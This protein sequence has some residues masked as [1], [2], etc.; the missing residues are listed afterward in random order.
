MTRLELDPAELTRLNRLLLEEAF[1]DHIR[2]IS[3]IH[4]ERIYRQIHAGAGSAALCFSGGGIRSATFALGVAQGLA[5][6]GVL[7]H[8]DYLSTV[9]GGGYIGSWL[10][11][12]IHHAGGVDAVCDKLKAGKPDSVTDPEPEPLSHLRKYSNYL[13]PKLGLFS[14]DTWVLAATYLRNLL[15]NWV[16]FA[17]ILLALFALPRVHASLLNLTPPD[18]LIAAGFFSGFLLA[19]WGMAYSAMNRPAARDDLQRHSRGWFL[20]RDQQSFLLWCLAPM[21][22]AAICITTS[23][24]WVQNGLDTDTSNAALKWFLGIVGGTPEVKPEIMN[25]CLLGAVL[26]FAGW[27]LAE[28][29][30]QRWRAGKWADLRKE[31]FLTLVIGAV[32]GVFLWSAASL[33]VRNANSALG[34]ML[35]SC[36]AAP[37]FLMLFLVAATL[38]IGVVSDVTSDEDREWWARMGAWLLIAIVGWSLFG[39]LVLFAPLGLL[40]LPKL[41]GALGGISGLFTLIV[42]HNGS[43]AANKERKTKESPFAFS[44]DKALTLAAPISLAALVAGLSLA[45]SRLLVTAAKP[46]SPLVSD[47]KTYSGL[48]AGKDFCQVVSS[49]P[50]WLTAGFLLVGA[51]VGWLLSRFIN[52]NKFSLHAI[53]RNRLVRAYLGA[54]N[55]R[56]DPNPFT[57]FDPCDNLPLQELRDPGN[58]ARPQ[59]P[60]HIV[61]MA[62]NL[63]TGENLAWQERKAETFTASTLHCGNF[64]LGYRFT[65]HYALSLRKIGQPKNGLSLGTAMA[66]S[67]AAASPNQ[68][69]HSS[70]VVALLMTL[71]NV[72]L[73]WWLGNPGAMGHDT[74]H[75]SAPRSPVRHMVKEGLGL[76]DSTSPY[77]YLSDGGHFEN[78]GFYEMILRRCRLIVVSDAGCDPKCNLEDLGN[79]IRKVRVD[80]GVR[81]E[82]KKFDIFSRIGD[83]GKRLGKYCAVAEIDYGSIDEGARKGILIYLKPALCGDEPRDIYNYSRASQE[84]PHE[85]TG[86]Q[87]F[88][89]SQ[90]ESYRALG[91]FVIDRIYQDPLRAQPLDGQPA[92]ELSTFV[93]RACQYAECPPLDGWKEKVEVSSVNSPIA[94]TE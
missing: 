20:R 64:R 48:H 6:H 21:C 91:Q 94:K 28:C 39:A 12:W 80:L 18:W 93:A 89:E 47:L 73:G 9:S 23:W 46:L 1:P 57:G 3:D 61:N 87:W 35:F 37:V 22:A 16:V 41:L 71:F 42:G 7:K 30:L 81:I 63:V 84:F 50:W 78:L 58:S 55:P 38:F 43:T 90:F 67:G 27:L 60:L 11:S 25:Y 83:E 32:G 2:K 8:F 36:F 26:H 17:P 14:A 56:R 10:S 31:F 53:Y 5:K 82:I 72:R 70:P 24:S 86:D 76:T 85:T 15:L 4:L 66:V 19:A 44:L 33:S 54:S 68:G 34:S 49:A 29:F 88:S 52:V 13:S 77:V 40:A 69:Y 75:D 45:T 59:R 51:F 92:D 65:K 74:F 79:A 62:L